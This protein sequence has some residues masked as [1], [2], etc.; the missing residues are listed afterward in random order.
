MPPGR[1]RGRLVEDQHARVTEQR[2]GDA[3]PLAHAE[4]VV[5]DPPAGLVRRQADQ[6]QHLVDAACGRPIIRWATVRI[7]GPCGPRA[8]PRRRA[9]R[10][11]PGP[12]W[13]GRRSAARR[14]RRIRRWRGEPDHD[15]HRGGLPGAVGP[16]KAGD[17][18]GRAVNVTSSTAVKPAYFLVS[19]WTVI[20]SGSL[21]GAGVA[22]IG[23]AAGTT[24]DPAPECP[25]GRPREPGSPSC[26]GGCGVTGMCEGVWPLSQT[27]CRLGP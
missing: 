21:A 3:E 6:V 14:P 23:E 18:A 2:R 5:A 16:E 12:G 11:P 19:D 4:R 10:R 22:H 9:G 25:Q 17:P 26:R 1:A 20:M 24:P 8:A 15:P 7:S 27:A 13:A